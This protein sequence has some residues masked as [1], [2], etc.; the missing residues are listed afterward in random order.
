MA[1]PEKEN[2][3][4]SPKTQLCIFSGYVAG[5]LHS[6]PNWAYV[7]PGPV[8]L[9]LEPENQYDPSA[10][11]VGSGQKLGYIPREATVVLHLAKAKGL[12][13][14]AFI[15]ELSQTKFKEILIRVW[16]EVTL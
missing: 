6:K 9:T 5:V 12:D 2:Y 11:R 14:K 10:I 15:V 4:T 1:N 16:V 7:K 13:P 8:A 3:V